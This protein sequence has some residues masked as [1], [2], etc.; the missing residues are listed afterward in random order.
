MGLA[1]NKDHL[2]LHM[3]VAI[4][5]FTAI[6][7]V[8]IT[9][10]PVEIV[11]YRTILSAVVMV[12]VLK[13]R[14]ESFL[15]SSSKD[16]LKVMLTGVVIAIH[17]ILFF[18]AARVSNVS[19]SLIGLATATLWTSLLE[20]IF[21]RRKFYWYE[22]VLGL[23][24]ILGLYIIL[25]VEFEYALGLVMSIVSGLGAAIFSIFNGQFTKRH[26]PFQITFLEMTGAAIG[27]ALFLPFYGLYFTDGMGLQFQASGEDWLYI[28]ILAGVCTVYAFSASVE[29]MKRVSAFMVN[30]TLNLEPIYGIILA[31]LFFGESEEMG[32]GFYLGGA[33]ILF[34]VLIYPLLKRKS[35]KRSLKM[36]HS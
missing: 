20:P 8:L 2:K 25:Q 13:F 14:S 11:F 30:L 1:V 16:T 23:L 26:S 10:P 29:L 5:G 28:A 35:A 36:G 21:A 22:F 31:L 24:V 7:G 9:I 15:L 3:L 4:W 17:W 33:V 27:I 12:G 19:I 34:S 32:L 18:G 6:L